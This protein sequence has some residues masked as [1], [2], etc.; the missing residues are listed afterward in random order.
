MTIITILKVKLLFNK[1]IQALNEGSQNQ[2][3]NIVNSN[4]INTN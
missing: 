1:P 4:E 2:P 3:R